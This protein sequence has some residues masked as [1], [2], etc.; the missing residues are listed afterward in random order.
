MKKILFVL[1][2]TGL[3]ISSGPVLAKD[4]FYIGGDLGIAVAP[5]MDLIGSDDDVGTPSDGFVNSDAAQ[6]PSRSPSNFYNDDIGG[7]TGILAGVALGYRLGSFRVEGEYLYR[8][9][10]F[11]EVRNTRLGDEAVN[12]DKS[13][14]EL[15]LIEGGVDDVL[16]HNFFANLYYDYRSE[17]K[18]TPYVGVGVGFARVNLDYY[19][20]WRRNQNAQAITT[21]HDNPDFDQDDYDPDDPSSE[22]PCV[23]KVCR[24]RNL[25]LAGTTTLGRAKLSDTMFGYQVIAGVDYQISDPVTIGLKFR[26]ADFGEFESEPRD[27][28]QLRSHD[29]AIRPGGERIQYK[30]VTDD[31]Q[32]WGVSLNMKYQF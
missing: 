15:D 25:G 11:D 27:W 4:G 1:V 3:L 12:I 13:K 19:Q 18:F 16:S 8:G 14:Q 7:A 22:L 21:F 9:T 10:T 20:N 30:V 31:I 29:S 26:W 23:S 17:S 2:V 32:F 6:S 28:D 24:D 5:S